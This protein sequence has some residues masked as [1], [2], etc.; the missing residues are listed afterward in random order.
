[1]E[2]PDTECRKQRKEDIENIKKTLYGRDGA[3]GIVH[4]TAK[5]VPKK[6]LFYILGALFLAVITSGYSGYSRLHAG[7]LQHE[8]NVRLIQQNAVAIKE[9]TKVAQKN[10]VRQERIDTKLENV[11]EHLDDIK[12]TL[13]LMR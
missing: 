8:E 4:C 5:L 13:K 12:E 10:E 11:E 7:E 3:S 6:W 1:M 9:L 2:C